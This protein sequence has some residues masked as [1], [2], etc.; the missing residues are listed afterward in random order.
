MKA[1]E[2]QSTKSE[3]YT[4]SSPAAEQYGAGWPPSPGERSEWPLPPVGGNAAAEEQKYQSVPDYPSQAHL[5]G[6]L[7]SGALFAHPTQEYAEF[8]QNILTCPSSSA[9]TA[10]VSA[11]LSGLV[12][13]DV[14]NVKEV[15]ASGTSSGAPVVRS[16]TVAD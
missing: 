12:E 7:P 15:L 8:R 10:V 16:R 4:Y 6:L 9:S 11:A 3:I 1:V 2:E 5:R 13:V 14:F